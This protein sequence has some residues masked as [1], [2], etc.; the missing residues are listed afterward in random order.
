MGGRKKSNTRLSNVDAAAMRSVNCSEQTGV[1][2]SR[3]G[4]YGP[5]AAH[6]AAHGEDAQ[7]SVSLG[8]SCV[9]SGLR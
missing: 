4:R 3:V 9:G 5:I 8:P 1:M 6:A 2:T 7:Q